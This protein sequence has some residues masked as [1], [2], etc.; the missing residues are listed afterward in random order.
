MK[1]LSFTINGVDFS[2]VCNENAFTAGATPVY[3]E[4]IETMDRERR[5]VIQR[6]RGYCR[7]GLNDMTDAEAQALAA[8]LR[9]DELVIGYPNRALGSTQVSQK[10]TVDAMELSFLLHDV[11]GNYW[12]G[13]QLTFTER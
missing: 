3:S 9:A 7:V 8:A 13:K 11:S 6:W 12:S 2:A 10:M 5:S 4:E 1:N